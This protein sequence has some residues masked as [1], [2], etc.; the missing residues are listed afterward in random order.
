MTQANTNTSIRSASDSPNVLKVKETYFLA[1]LLLIVACAAAFI[2]G[3]IDKHAFL[4]YGDAASHIVK[5]REL[6]DSRSPGI[7][8][9][10]TVWLPLPHILLMPFA[11]ID[12]LFF[13]GLAGAALGVPCLI[14]TSV[15]IF[16]IVLRLTGSHPAALLS[17]CLFGLNPN[18]VYMALTPM[19]ESS[20][21][22]FVA[23][24]GYAFLRWADDGADS[25]LLLTA[26][27]VMFA[28]LCRYEAWPL[29]PLVSF[30]ALG[31]RV[32]VLE[33]EE[34]GTL[35]PNVGDR[36]H[37]RSRNCSLACLESVSIW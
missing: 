28:S 2:L 5:A 24:G 35:G 12:A 27:A 19:S 34:L 18:V 26:V 22:F 29:V 1:F 6:I 14:G 20:L 16:S 11:V 8:S 4:Y 13:S 31:Q 25:W 7:E 17:A 32:F 15:L 21:F 9:I 10:G 3:G 36:A 33:E 30:I 37:Q 23:L